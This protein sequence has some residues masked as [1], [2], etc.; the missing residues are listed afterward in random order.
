MTIV[1]APIQN[2]F[3]LVK[4]NIKNKAVSFDEKPIL[5]HY[6]GY[7]VISPNFFD[8]IQKRTIDLKDGKGIIE[9]IKKLIRKNQVNIYRETKWKI[10]MYFWNLVLFPITYPLPKIPVGGAIFFFKNNFL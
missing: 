5:N 7:A 6:I 9:A 10:I 4:W 8:K 2:P 3:G 1:V